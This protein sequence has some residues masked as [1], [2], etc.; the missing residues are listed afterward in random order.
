MFAVRLANTK[1]I[2]I[3]VGWSGANSP[4]TSGPSV[5]IDTNFTCGDEGCLFDIEADAGEHNDL[6]KQQPAVAAQLR[7]RMTEL[8][9]TWFN[10]D[11]GAPDPGYAAQIVKN[12][13]YL[14]PWLP[15]G[16]GDGFE[17]EPAEL[18]VG[19]RAGR[20]ATLE[21]DGSQSRPFATI[22]AAVAAVRQLPQATRCRAG[23]VRVTVAGGWYA[24]GLHLTQ[25][26]SGCGHRAPVIYRAA[27]D[28]PKPVVVH[29]GAVIPASS[30]H[31]GPV[32]AN[33]LT[34]WTADLRELGLASLAASSGRFNT[35]WVC[36]NGRR[37]ELF[38]GG[39]AMTLARHPNRADVD[40]TWQYL[41]QGRTVSPT[42]FLAGTDDTAGGSPVPASAE[43]LNASAMRDAW[44]HGY[45]SC[46]CSSFV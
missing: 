32:L 24:E 39:R 23:G 11:R 38:V 29:G 35:G 34:V 15:A 40:G 25:A 26:D 45:W 46:E 14:G 28:D 43:W 18:H 22:A 6:V 2:T 17:S 7:R 10:P 20:A 5:S 33:G 36:A 19:R 12:G 37:T 41:R 21:A 27:P 9:A 4:N 3:S 8:D 44:A 1:S 16:D 30:L 31:K 13:G 42:S